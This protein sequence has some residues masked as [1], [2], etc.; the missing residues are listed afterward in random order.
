MH[1]IFSLKDIDCTGSSEPPVRMLP[2]CYA[3]ILF[4]K[5]SRMTWAIG[6]GIS[7]FIEAKGE[8]NFLLEGFAIPA[9]GLLYHG[10]NEHG[11]V[12]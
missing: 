11:R 3:S 2:N 8:H 10:D 6:D 7:E 5:T 1:T 12:W 4:E 9:R